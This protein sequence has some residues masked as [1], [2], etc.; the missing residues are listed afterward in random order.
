[1]TRFHIVTIN[2]N[3]LAGLIKTHVSVQAQTY[4]NFRWI[5][6]D[7]NSTDGAVEWLAELDNDYTVSNSERD[8]SLYDAMNKGLVKAI[9]EPGYTLFLN[10]GDTFHDPS[11][12]EK[13]AKAIEASA[14]KP[15]YVYGDYCLSNG[16]GE[17][18]EVKAKPIA[19]LK[20]GMVTSHQAMYFENERL[21][22]IRFREDYPLS[23]DYCMIIEFVSGVTP[24]HGVL[25][26]PDILCDFDTTGVS[27]VRRFDALKED[28]AI[29]KRYMKISN[30][31]ASLLYVLHYLHTHTKLLR[32]QLGK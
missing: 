32:G 16:Q 22:K 23:A 10:S 27:Q 20:T 29:R 1:M 11:V 13:V 15:E 21:S 8:R 3:N 18:R 25:Q 9:T 17:L 5:V 26:L 7:G 24:P 2:R 30:A 19:R 31:Q 12:L 28:M 6:V 4:R 14:G